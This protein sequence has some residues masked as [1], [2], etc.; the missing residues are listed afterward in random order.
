M[1][2]TSTAGVV[3]DRDVLGSVTLV[4]DQLDEGL[5]VLVLAVQVQAGLDE[6]THEPLEVIDTQA[7]VG[8]D[9]LVQRRRGHPVGRLEPQERLDVLVADLVTN[10]L[11]LVFTHRRLP[12]GPSRTFRRPAV[13]PPR[14]TCLNAYVR[15]RYAGRPRHGR[16]GS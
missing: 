15:Y 12:T 10:H 13:Y 14:P 7:T 5:A 1:L 9:Q 11:F 4:G 16:W 3:D 2:A 8:L 6:E